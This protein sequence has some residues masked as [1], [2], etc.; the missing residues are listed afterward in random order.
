[1]KCIIIERTQDCGKTSLSNYLRKN[2][3]SSNLC[4]LAGNKDKTEIGKKKSGEMYFALLE[5]MKKIE[6]S[7]LNLIFDRTFFTEQV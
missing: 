4:R 3:A 2:L 5:Y 1:M 6:N 7:N